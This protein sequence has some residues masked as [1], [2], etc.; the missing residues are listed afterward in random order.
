M[1]RI[2]RPADPVAVGVF[3]RAPVPGEAK[4]RLVPVLGEDAAAEL[5]GLLVRRA[6]ATA[7]ESGVGEVILWCSPDA[8]HP[9]FAR[10]AADFGVALRAQSGGHLGERMAS[11]LADMLGA[12]RRAL[13]IGS[14]C[15]ALK[16]DD[17]RE[18]ARSLATHEAVLQPAEDGG[19]VMVGLSQAAPSLFE[20]IR[21]G[22]ASVMKDTRSRL[23]TAKLRW[24]ELPMR[25]DVDRPE[26]YRRLVET[27]LLAEGM[28]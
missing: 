4:T 11:A 28:P 9:F 24:R 18:A 5:H 15:P 25:W 17:L 27:G 23:R 20:G 3:A 13:L 10:C 19:Y 26:D 6:L 16:A 2:A 1:A 8:G 12:N 14:D 7:K 21:W 22:E